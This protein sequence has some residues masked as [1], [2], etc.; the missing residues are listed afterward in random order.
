MSGNDPWHFTVKFPLVVAPHCYQCTPYLTSDFAYLQLPNIGYNKGYSMKLKGSWGVSKTFHVPVLINSD[1]FFITLSYIRLD[2]SAIFSLS[3]EMLSC[4]TFLTPPFFSSLDFSGLHV[5]WK[6][7][8]AVFLC[9]GSFCPEWKKPTR[10][11]QLSHGR[12]VNLHTPPS[13][14]QG[15]HNTYGNF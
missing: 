6:S 11:K 4:S 2:A 14:K 13:S 10:T 12:G 1:Q 15:K 3:L 5:G 9:V 7:F 8:R